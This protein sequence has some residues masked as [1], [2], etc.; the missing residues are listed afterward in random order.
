[1]PALADYLAAQQTHG[2]QLLVV[3]ALTDEDLATLLA[4]S[5][6][7]LPGAL[8]CGSAGLIEPLARSYAKTQ[9]LTPLAAPEQPLALR[10]PLLAVMGSGSAMAHRQLAALRELPSVRMVAFH[11]DL[12]ATAV[13]PQQGRAPQG[14][15]L[16]L[17][18]PAPNT[19]LEGEAA[20]CLA[21]QVATLV[22]DLVPLIQPATLLL[23]GGDTTVHVLE[24][25][26]IMRLRVVCEILPG[27]P[28][29]EGVTADQQRYRIITKA[30]NFGDERTL[31]KLVTRL[32]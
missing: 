30:G 16:H 9:R 21:G 15:V 14:W 31:L 2:T 29:L 17:P 3:D 5:Q 11:S 4:A 32:H 20:R 6:S 7:A 25:L 26:A 27:I 22:A 28:L 1:V 12:T 24:Q 23:V 8:L 19:S 18:P 10:S 13:I